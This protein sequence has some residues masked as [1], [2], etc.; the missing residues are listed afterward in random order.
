MKKGIFSVLS[1]VITSFGWL[2]QVKKENAV[3]TIQAM[4]FHK[5]NL[6]GWRYKKGKE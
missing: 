2:W 4:V 3:W 1:C 6:V 5:Y